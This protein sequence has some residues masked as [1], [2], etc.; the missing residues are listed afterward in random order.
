MTLA[1]LCSG[2]GP[3]HPAMFAVTGDAPAAAALFDH[4]AALL[5][6]RDPRTLVRDADEAVTLHG[7]RVGPD[8]LHAARQQ[9][10]WPTLPDLTRGRRIVARLQCRRGW[11]LGRRRD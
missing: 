9:R 1:L 8:P 7:N 4:A 11:C 10:P 6:G 3:Q 2:Q 5:G